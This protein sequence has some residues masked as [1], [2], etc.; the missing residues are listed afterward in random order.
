MS[1][2]CP[3]DVILWTVACQAL[4]SME[5]SRQDGEGDEREGF[6]EVWQKTTKFYKAIILQLK[7][8]KK[9]NTGMGCYALLQ[10]IFLTQ[11]SNPCLLCILHWQEGSLPSAPITWYLF[12]SF[13]LTSLCSSTSLEGTQ[14]CSFVWLSTIPLYIC[15]TTSL[16]SHLLMGT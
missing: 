9:K 4:L 16:S 13:W 11:G 5:F 2:S 8:N 10:G 1:D 15:A 12:F 6:M 14:I 3:T 7:N